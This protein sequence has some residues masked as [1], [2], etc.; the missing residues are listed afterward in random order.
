[1]KMHERNTLNVVSVYPNLS[2]LTSKYNTDVKASSN[3]KTSNDTTLIINVIF[4]PLALSSKQRGLGC[5]VIV[6]ASLEFLCIDSDESV[7]ADVTNEGEVM[8]KN[9]LVAFL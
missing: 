9:T 6:S 5:A 1:M 4:E 3:T 8:E 2:N 7:V